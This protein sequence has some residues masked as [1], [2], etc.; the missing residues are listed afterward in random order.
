MSQLGIATYGF[1]SAIK[2]TVIRLKI[3]KKTSAAEVNIGKTCRIQP[4]EVIFN[5]ASAHRTIYGNK[6][7]VQ[8]GDIYKVW[9]QNINVIS[10]FTEVDKVAHARKKKLLVSVFTDRL[11]D[12]PKR[13]S[14]SM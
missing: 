9:R 10:T 5:S 14:F 4:N 8:K 2:Y 1:G 6:A 7:N 3:A 12:P 11:F 13:S